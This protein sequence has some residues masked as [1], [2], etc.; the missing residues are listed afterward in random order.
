[1]L[2]LLWL[3]GLDAEDWLLKL[4]LDSD[5][6]LDRLLL[7]LLLNPRLLS[8]DGLLALLRLLSD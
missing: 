3:L 4:E 1:M 6:S 7:E 5:D 2:L 8:D